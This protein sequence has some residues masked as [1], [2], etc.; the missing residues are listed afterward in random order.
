MGT[1]HKAPVWF[2]V[3]AV[4]ALAWN[5]VGVA[6]YI[7]QA[8]MTPEALAALSEAE[9]ALLEATPAWATAAFAIAVFGGA[10][11]SLLLLLRSRVALPVLVLSLLGVIAQMS[12]V[13]FLSDALEVYGPGGLAM[14]VTVLALSLLLPFFARHAARRRWIA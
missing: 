3:V 1:T 8:T 6:A 9:R 11:G 5:A 14:P 10:A 7:Q 13:L 2:W 4:F 12:Y